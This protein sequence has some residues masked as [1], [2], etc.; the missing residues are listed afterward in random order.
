MQARVLRNAAFFTGFVDANE[1]HR[2]RFSATIA[3]HKYP[4]S[5]SRSEPGQGEEVE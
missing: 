5:G 3:G 2:E 1:Q 4:V